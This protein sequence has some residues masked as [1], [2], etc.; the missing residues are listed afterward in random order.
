VTRCL[1]ALLLLCAAQ[2]W[3]GP[4][5]FM[6]DLNG[7]YGSAEYH[8]RVSEAVVAMIEL[9]PEAVVIAGD[10]IAGQVSPPL[11]DAQIEAMWASFDQTVYKPLRRHG[12]QVLAVPGNHDASIYSEFS[13]ERRAYE[14]FWRER[15]PTLS[16]SPGSEYP[17]YYGVALAESD[18]VG[19]DVT[20]PGALSE[21]Q[22]LF[23][24]QRREAARARGQLLL[25][26]SHLPMY[27]VSVGR[28]EEVFTSRLTPVNGELWIAG[29]HH[30][31]YAAV[32]PG[33]GIQLSLPPLGGNRRTW[34]GSQLKTSF[35]FA[36]TD[37]DGAPVLFAWPGYEPTGSQPGPPAIGDLRRIEATLN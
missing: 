24:A 4:P 33:G 35:G 36:S 31:Y 25:V 9:Q 5:V 3:A 13:S 7:R 37:R 12:I 34:L 11:T 17:W 32:T 20:A 10:M 30:A 23:L 2:G 28:K 14:Q 26:A 15:P 22:E 16:L 29:H 6:A 8:D 19:L 27:P 18:F 21:E 1:A